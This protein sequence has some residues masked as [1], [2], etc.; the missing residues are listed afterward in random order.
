METNKLDPLQTVNE[1][2][3]DCYGPTDEVMKRLLLCPLCAGH[4]HFNHLTDYRNNLVQE[5]ARCPDCAI[6]VRSRRHKMQ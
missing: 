1:E 6:R 3:R 5:V 4:L 2:Y